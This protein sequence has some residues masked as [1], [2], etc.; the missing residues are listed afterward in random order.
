[1]SEWWHL[2]F[3]VGNCIL[4]TA[5]NGDRAVVMLMINAA[6]VQ[7]PLNFYCVQQRDWLMFSM[8]AIIRSCQSDRYCQV[9]ASLAFS[10][11]DSDV[12]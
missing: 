10:E 3:A 12:F 5:L 8:S 11:A 4:S 6:A 9:V 7:E 1:M 2:L